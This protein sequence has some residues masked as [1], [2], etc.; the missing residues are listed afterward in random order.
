M[1]GKASA[2]V[3]RG[4]FGGKPPRDLMDALESGSVYSNLLQESWRHQLTLF[5]IVSFFETKSNVSIFSLLKSW[6]EA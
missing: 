4:I 5:K 3:V 1:L 2:H 6:S